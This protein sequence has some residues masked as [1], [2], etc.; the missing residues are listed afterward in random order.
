MNIK[1]FARFSIQQKFFAAMALGFLGFAFYFAA[2]LSFSRENQE[3]MNALVEHRLPMLELLENLSKGIADVNDAVVQC[4]V[5]GGLESVAN[6]ESSN[7]KVL[8]GIEELKKQKSE[9]LENLVNIEKKYREAYRG[10]HEL[11]QNV[12]AGLDQLSAVQGKLQ[13]YAKDLNTLEAWALEIKSQE[14]E[15]LRASIDSVN[16]GSRNAMYAGWVLMI[17]VLPFSLFFYYMT[18]RISMNLQSVSGR[19]SEVSQNMLKISS[20]A[21]TSSSKLASSSAQQATAVSESMSSMEEMKSKLSQ[22]VR[23]S[24]EALRSSEESFREAADGKVVIDSLRAAMVDIER[25]YEQLE[26][27]NQVVRMIGDKTNIINDIVFK[28]QLLSFNAS[29]EAARAGQHGRGFAVVAA[30]VGKLAEMSGKAAQEIGKL[31]DHSTKKVAEIVENTKYKVG[32]ANDMSQKCATVF[33]R[34]TERAGQV[35]SMVDSITDAAS[36]QESGIHQVGHAMGDMQDSVSET[37]R[38]AHAISQLSQ[39]LRGHSQ[40]L[41]ATVDKLDILVHGEKVTETSVE[42]PPS[43]LGPSAPAST[44]LRR[45]A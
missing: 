40:S 20:D 37:D 41:A 4:A 32:S 3:L 6:L 28:T 34:I 10:A 8:A 1:H 21:S 14:S 2:N 7:K 35:K 30:E 45:S 22:T 17:A 19:L 13:R 18:R 9:R 27:V 29:I 25:S 44:S 15:D 12:V 42:P 24:A 39:L 33:E 36:E 11:V 31:L 16:K 5:S 26:E 38:M 43:T 23:H